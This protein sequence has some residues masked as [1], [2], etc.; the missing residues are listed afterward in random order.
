MAARWDPQ[1]QLSPRVLD[2]AERVLG[3]VLTSP[4]ADAPEEHSS[5]WE[6]ASL[7]DAA[8]RA[9]CNLRPEH[10]PE[11]R[12][13]VLA[14]TENSLA[15]IRAIWHARQQGDPAPT[16]PAPPVAPAAAAEI[17]PLLARFLAEP[18]NRESV[19]NEL[20]EQHGLGAFPVV[21][22]E[23][24]KAAPRSEERKVL[25]ALALDLG[26][27]VREVVLPGE[28]LPPALADELRALRGKPLVAEHL[29]SVVHASYSAVPDGKTGFRLDV[30]GAG[31]AFGCTLR[32]RWSEAKFPHAREEWAWIVTSA[33]QLP[34]K[35][36]DAE[37]RELAF[38]H[39]VADAIA[40]AR[41]RLA[42]G[43]AEINFYTHRGTP[44]GGATAP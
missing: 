26:W 39:K 23:R 6:D 43:A 3:M 17:Q 22:A 30:R 9:L 21:N 20:I 44:R 14:E 32:F 34:A 25:D 12:S 13:F 27:T 38:A 28:P 41:P 10:Y 1:S 18:Q 16:K 11:R 5:E 8:A 19:R 36:S 42:N 29:A 33:R 31:D 37:V 40:A 35:R 4:A 2:A 15:D 7:S 24:E